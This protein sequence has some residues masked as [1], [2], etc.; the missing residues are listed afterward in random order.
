MRVLTSLFQRHLLR[1]EPDTDLGACSVN[2]VW[3]N[4]NSPL[5]DHAP[6]TLCSVNLTLFDMA[7]KN[8]QRYP[9][10]QFNIWVDYALLD[11]KSRFLWT[12]MLI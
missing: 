4:A 9:D 10:S 1:R 5:K 7:Y 6:S 2:Y 8:A 12:A 3:L 11:Q